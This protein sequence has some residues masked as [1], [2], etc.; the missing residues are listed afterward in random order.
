MSSSGV[1]R[2]GTHLPTL[3]GS[4]VMTILERAGF[5]RVRETGHAIYRKGSRTVPV[6]THPGDV[7]RGTLRSIIRLS[8]MDVDEFLEFR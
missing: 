4:E 3:K 1:E 6:P 5:V 2:M 7:P 8:G